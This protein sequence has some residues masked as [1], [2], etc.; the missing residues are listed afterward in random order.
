M[1][2]KNLTNAGLGVTITLVRVDL[3]PV[4]QFGKLKR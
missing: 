4:E 3:T 2:L 1:G